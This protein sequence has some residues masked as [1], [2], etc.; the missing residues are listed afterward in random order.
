VGK[1]ENH[2][3][4]RLDAATLA[5]VEAW[6][7]DDR[8]DRP[9]VTRS[10]VLRVLIAIGLEHADRDGGTEFRAFLGRSRTAKVL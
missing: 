9:Q 1:R 6:I 5:R 8:S 10:D 4:F 2:V 7:P 3:S